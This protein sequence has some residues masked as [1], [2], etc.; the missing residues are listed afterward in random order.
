MRRG[1]KLKVFK[2]SALMER[3]MM[4]NAKFLI[5]G[6]KAKGEGSD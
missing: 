6:T 5:K 4:D 2:M 1:G 3:R